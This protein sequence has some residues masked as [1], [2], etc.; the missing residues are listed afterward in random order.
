MKF[1][2]P[3]T[4]N[5]FMGALSIKLTLCLHHEI[6]HTLSWFVFVW[7]RCCWLNELPLECYAEFVVPLIN[8]LF[9]GILGICDSVQIH[10]WSTFV[11][12]FPTSTLILSFEFI[13]IY[14]PYLSE[15]SF[16]V[17]FMLWCLKIWRRFLVRAIWIYFS[18]NLYFIASL[19]WY[20][21]FMPVTIYNFAQW[22]VPYQFGYV[23]SRVGLKQPVI[24]DTVSGQLP[25]W[26]HFTSCHPVC[27]LIPTVSGCNYKSSVYS[28]SYEWL[29]FRIGV[30]S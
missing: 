10:I 2:R 15:T 13:Y 18:D 6:Y 24:V 14:M 17:V 3:L 9:C 21:L 4:Q 26:A 22:I 12:S 11:V 23:L 25:T 7:R 30:T 5:N 1:I 19:I 20:V 16:G 27:I 8:T 29:K 28:G